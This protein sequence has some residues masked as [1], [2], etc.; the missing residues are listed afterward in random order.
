MTDVNT[1]DIF[2]SRRFF[3]NKSSQANWTC[4]GQPEPLVAATLLFPVL[5]LGTVYQLNCVCWRCPWPPRQH[6]LTCACSV[7]DFT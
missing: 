1:I 4:N 6:W 5:R 3:N 7:S 2:L